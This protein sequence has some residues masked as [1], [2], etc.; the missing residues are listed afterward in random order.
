MKSSLREAIVRQFGRPTG[1]VGRLVGLVMA[2]R[3]SNR[4]RN[5][6]TIELLQ[7]QP[8]DRVLEIGYGPGDRHPVG[9]RARRSRD[10]GRCRP[11]RADAP[12]GGAPERPRH[13][14]GARRS[15]PCRYST[16][17]STGYSP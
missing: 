12:S 2:T 7:I 11:L 17:D 13:S 3:T 10:G 6:R 9:R 14:D 8:D 5:R 1:I 15:M 4:E 16:A